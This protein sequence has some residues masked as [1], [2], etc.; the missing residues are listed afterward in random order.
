VTRRHVP[1]SKPAHRTFPGGTP[2]CNGGI[3]D[4]PSDS[5]INIDDVV[6]SPWMGLHYRHELLLHYKHEELERREC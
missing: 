5:L 1:S 6:A 3:D 2:D 4:A